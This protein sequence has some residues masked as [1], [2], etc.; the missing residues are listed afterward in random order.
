MPSNSPLSNPM[1]AQAPPLPDY[2]HPPVTEVVLSVQF[3]PLAG[4][5]VLHVGPLW[6]K[7]RER[8]P[9]FEEQALLAP[10][11]ETLS[12]SNRPDIR[13]QFDFGEKPT[14]PRLWFL[15]APGNRLLQIQPDRFIHNWRKAGE[16]DTYPRYEAIRETFE[17][18]FRVFQQYIAEADL[19]IIQPNQCEVTYL[20]QIVPGHCWSRLGQVEGALSLW[21]GPMQG[22]ALEE[23]EDVRIAMRYRLHDSEG[24][25]IGR[26]HVNLE[27]RRRVT[28]GTPILF[29]NLTARGR[30]IGAGIQEVLAMLDLGRERIV[31][32]FTA[33]TSPGQHRMWGRQDA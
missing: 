12:E 18:E 17:Q 27:P 3:A 33:I 9:R 19:G 22:A 7:F 24:A 11:L 15:D 31:H 6:E 14:L 26:L 20:N 1:R 2:E 13:L 23:P 28:D 16:G 25:P 29:L 5:N 30:P 21:N 8:Y 10:I 4:L 32:T